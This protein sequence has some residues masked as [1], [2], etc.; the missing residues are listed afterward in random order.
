MSTID[1]LLNH[2]T[3]IALDC[4][5]GTDPAEAS[6]SCR[7]HVPNA[8]RYTYERKPRAAQRPGCPLSVSDI[9]VLASRWLQRRGVRVHCTNVGMLQ[10]EQKRLWVADIT[11]ERSGRI[12]IAATYYSRRRKGRARAHMQE[13]AASLAD[14]CRRCYKLSGAVGALINVYGDGKTEG[15]FLEPKGDIP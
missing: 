10:P 8:E 3:V 9:A 5:P 11:G 1:C 12:V 6:W 14:V 7:V 15:A 2:P 4:E 13:Y